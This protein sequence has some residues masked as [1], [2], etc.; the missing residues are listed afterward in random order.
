MA[1]DWLFERHAIKKDALLKSIEVDLKLSASTLTYTSTE[2]T[3]SISLD[4]VFGATQ[5]TNSSPFPSK[6]TTATVKDVEG[7]TSVIVHSLKLVDGTTDKPPLYQPL[8]LELAS[9]SEALELKTAVR[10]ILSA[11]RKPIYVVI[12]PFAGKK[13]AVQT[14]ETASLPMLQAAGIKTEVHLTTHALHAT[15]LIT[16]LNPDLYS[17]I[18]VFGGDGTFHEVLNGIMTRADWEVATK[19]P[20][21][22]VGGGSSNAFTK[23]TDALYPELATLAVIKGCTK[24]MDIFSVITPKQVMFSHLEVLF[25]LIADLDIESDRYRWLGP[26]RFTMAAVLKFKPSRW[27]RKYKG[28]LYMLPYEPSKEKAEVAAKEYQTEAAKTLGNL[29]KPAGFQNHTVSS[30]GNETLGYNGPPLRYTASPT[31]HLSWPV[32]DSHF[33]FFVAMNLPFASP[34]W[35]TS[36]FA[37]FG[38]GAMD[39]IWAENLVRSQV[40]PLLND[41]AA[42]LHLKLPGIQFQKTRAWVLEP[43]GWGKGMPDPNKVKS[44]SKKDKNA[45]Q[46]GYMDISGEEIE[47]GPIRVEIHSDIVK[48]IVP[49]WLDE[50]KW[51]RE[52]AS[53]R[54]KGAKL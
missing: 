18:A 7:G 25:A 45:L 17:C 12:N 11:D 22:M 9:S 10:S 32:V 27:L 42:G 30:R 36:E 29:T 1:A 49:S 47:Y 41:Q 33:T 14:Y 53:I 46:K 24:Y 26:E 6:L 44:G 51:G 54:L 38:D 15:E 5:S 40:L 20:L 50:D 16:D 52:I 28:K 19:L 2:G 13:L 39:I 21:A 8:L 4:F 34:D 35:L 3:V 48:V 37:R 23:N 43:E 31:A